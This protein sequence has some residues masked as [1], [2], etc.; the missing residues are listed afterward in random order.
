M[1][2]SIQDGQAIEAE[3]G[4]I[5]A[6][7]RGFIGRCPACGEGALFCAYLKVHDSCPVCH[8]ELHHQKADDAPP[9]VTMFA[10]GH[11]V[12][13]LLL[14]AEPL[15]STMPLWLEALI[16]STV[17]VC[18]SLALLPRVKGAVVA[19]QWSLRMHGFGDEV[20]SEPTI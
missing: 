9:Y 5:R 19:L 6:M 17:T 20:S 12:V 2:L 10:V 3:R 14:A 1:T 13:A 4:K 15:T 7:G 8:E 11:I 16:W 18:L